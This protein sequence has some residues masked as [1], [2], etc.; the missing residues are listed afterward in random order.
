MLQSQRSRWKAGNRDLSIDCNHVLETLAI[1]SAEFR[2]TLAEPTPQI[3]KLFFTH[4]LSLNISPFPL[5]DP[6]LC[7]LNTPTS[8]A[9]ARAGG[10]PP[11]DLI[12]VM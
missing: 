7:P 9:L 2:V 1:S 4:T 11:P 8:R 5:T 12:L 3:Q 10:N 6:F